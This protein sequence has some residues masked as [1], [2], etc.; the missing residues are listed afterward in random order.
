M[1]S[2]YKMDRDFAGLRPFLAVA[3]KSSFTAAAAELRVTPSAVSQSIRALEERLGIR[4]LQR[5]SRSVGLTEAGERFLARLQPALE[6]VQG[7]FE[8][9]AEHRAHPAGTLRLVVPRFAYGYVLQP[10]LS[11]FLAEYPDI[12]IDLYADDAVV[13]LASQGFDAAIRLGETLDRDMIAVRASE[14]QRLAVVGSPAYFT[15]HGTP[16]HPKDLQHH[17]CINYRRAPGAQVYRWEFTSRGRDFEVVVD[18]RLQ[19]NDREL[20]VSA[21]LDS[22]GLAYVA[23]SRIAPHLDSRRLVRVLERWCTPFPGLFLCYPSRKNAA[24]KLR[25][26]IDFFRARWV[27]PRRSATATPAPSGRRRA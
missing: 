5:T 7:A 8:S 17:N 3:E 12:R 26:L 9:V 23:E 15:K 13:D 11:D 16:K 18:G 14:D 20:M 22:L 10:H 24:P 21:A 25:A 1:K 19:V 27:L 4:L 6:Q 2:G